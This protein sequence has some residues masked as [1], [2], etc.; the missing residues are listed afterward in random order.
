MSSFIQIQLA[1]MEIQPFLIRTTYLGHPVWALSGQGKIIKIVKGFT[2]RLWLQ[3]RLT[4]NDDKGWKL[5]LYLCS[6]LEAFE[7]NSIGS[8]R[9]ICC[10]LDF[11]AE[12]KI[13]KGCSRPLFVLLYSQL[14]ETTRFFLQCLRQDFSAMPCIQL[15]IDWSCKTN[16]Q[17]F[18]GNRP[19][20][21]LQLLFQNLWICDH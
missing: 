14:R 5:M 1:P 11:V 6:E 15:M 18:R 16:D 10:R 4:K 21:V 9:V 19:F 17:K 3:N 20:N 13:E 8:T 12:G 2:K 7:P